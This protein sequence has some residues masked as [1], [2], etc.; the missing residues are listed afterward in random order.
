V[1]QEKGV[2]GAVGALTARVLAE[3]HRLRESRSGWMKAK[4]AVD[5]AFDG[6][7][8]VDTGGVTA[9]RFLTVPAHRRSQAVDHIA[10]DPDEFHNALA[11]LPVDMSEYT[12]VDYGS[13][14]GR[15]VLLAARAAFRR[16]IGVEFAVEL[17]RIAQQNVRTGVDEQR[18]T[19]I[20]LHCMDA[21]EFELPQTPLVL[22]LY[23]PF[24]PEVLKVVIMRVLASHACSPRPILVLYLNPFHDQLWIE[25]GFV[26]LARADNYM[27][28]QAVDPT[29]AA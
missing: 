9:V 29:Q 6:D 19:D 17:H 27:L 10:I 3:L 4:Q 21:G 14:K 16:V 25:A 15:A 18:R 23:H 12:F 11:A 7:L 26:Q 24:G 22:Y 28:L 20:E 8:G 1:L 5:R 2:L 13:G